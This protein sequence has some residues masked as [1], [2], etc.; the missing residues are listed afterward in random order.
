MDILEAGGSLI[1]RL[2]VPVIM[3]FVALSVLRSLDEIKRSQRRLEDRL[4]AMEARLP[5]SPSDGAVPPP[6]GAPPA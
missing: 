6:P 1:L 2:G 3:V 4:G 5:D